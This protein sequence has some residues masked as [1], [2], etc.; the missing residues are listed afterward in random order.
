MEVESL[1]LYIA[2]ILFRGC[3]CSKQFP[4]LLFTALNGLSDDDLGMLER[5]RAKLTSE[6]KEVILNLTET[7]D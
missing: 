6:R 7:P 4:Q 5:I 3:C 2:L 1:G